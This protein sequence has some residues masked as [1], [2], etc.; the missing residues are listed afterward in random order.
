MAP[1]N[2]LGGMTRTYCDRLGIAAPG[3]DELARRPGVK[4]NHLMFVAL[5][6]HGAPM[7]LE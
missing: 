3:V 5:L 4:L 1:R 6:E 2:P 7:T